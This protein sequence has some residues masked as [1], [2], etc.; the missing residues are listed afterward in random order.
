MQEAGHERA[1]GEWQTEWHVLPQLAVLAGTALSEAHV[2]VAGMRVDPGRMRANLGA[3][4]GLVMA[5]AQ[6]ITLATAMGREYAH[7]LVYDAALARSSGRKL[8]EVLPKVAGARGI[9]EL[10]PD[11]L[12]TAEDYLGDA[13]LTARF[14]LT[15]WARSPALTGDDRPLATLAAGH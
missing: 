2:V 9:L 5:E 11:P 1:A 15:S 10:L 3:D 4:G 14:T 7:D 6:M 8:A 13:E 12:I